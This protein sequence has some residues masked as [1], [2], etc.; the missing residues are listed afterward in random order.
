LEQIEQIISSA[1]KPTTICVVHASLGSEH[2]DGLAKLIRRGVEANVFI[3][4]NTHDLMES[5][6]DRQSRLAGLQKLLPLPTKQPAKPKDA[7]S[8]S[9]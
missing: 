8:N 5:T 7:G 1:R 3:S 4:V 9:A 6:S 2:V